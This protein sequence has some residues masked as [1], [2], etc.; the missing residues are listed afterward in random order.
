MMQS[1]NED[2]NAPTQHIDVEAAVLRR[3]I[4]HLQKNTELQNID[5]MILGGFCRNC[6]ANWYHEEAMK[7]GRSISKETAKRYIYGMPYEKWKELYQTEVSQEKL[8]LIKQEK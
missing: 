4:L 5:L 6:L 8:N 7:R 2:T 1:H 3:L